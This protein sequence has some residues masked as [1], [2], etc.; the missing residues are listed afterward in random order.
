MLK[1]YMLETCERRKGLRGRFRATGV[2]RERGVVRGEGRVPGVRDGGVYTGDHDR[3][4]R[5]Q[6]PE[7]WVYRSVGVGGGEGLV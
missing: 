5:L 7:Q 6:C 4:C 3:R 2:F 1:G